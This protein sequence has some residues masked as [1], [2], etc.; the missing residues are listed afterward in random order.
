MERCNKLAEHMQKRVR[1]GLPAAHRD[2]TG[3]EAREGGGEALG[4]TV[5]LIG[6]IE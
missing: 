1:L 5:V 2:R 3:R 6:G 4:I